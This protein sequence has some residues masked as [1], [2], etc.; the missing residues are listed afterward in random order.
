MSA[1]YYLSRGPTPEGP[2]EEARLVQM[3][4][5]G[6]LT[7]GGVCPVGQNQ[8][9][10]IDS[11]PVFAQALAARRGLAQPAPVAPTIPENYPAAPRAAAAEY[12]QPAA[13]AQPNVSA[14]GAQPT[15][16]KSN[17]GLVL[18][19]A[20]GV[21]VLLIGGIAI[22]VYFIFFSSGGAR[23]ISQAVPRD[24]ELLIDVPSVRKGLLDLHDVKFLDTSLRDDKQ[25]LDQAADSLAKAFDLSASDAV[26]L[27]AD[28]ETAGISAR[29]LESKPEV[30][31]ALG[32]RSA[33]PAEVLLKSAR[34][35][36]AGTVGQKGRRYTLA[37]KQLAPGAGQD[38]VAK[39][40][41][42]AEIGATDQEQL[43]WFPAQKVLALGDAALVSDVAQ[44]L[45]SGAAN[46]EQNPA[47]QAA[48][49]EFDPG[50]R[51]TAFVDPGALSNVSDPKTKQ[52]I[53]EYFTPA[54]PLT[55]S[56]R[57]NSAGF[58]SSVTA[59]I[60]GSKLPHDDSYEAPQALN[61]SDKLAAETF[62]YLA[63]ST[64]SKLTGADME[65]ML[66]DRLSTL[67]AHT[68]N[69]AEQ[70]LREFEQ[71]L[72]VSTAKLIDGIGG[73][74][75]LGL[76]AS[77]DTTLDQLNNE[78]AAASRVNVTYVQELKDQS[79]FQ[80]LATALKT[81]ILPSA[82]EVLLTPDGAGFTLSPRATP[83]PI[84]LRVKFIDKYLFITAGAN[85]LCDRAE[86]AFTKGTST[87]KD[88]SAHQTALAALPDASHFRLWLDTG[89]LL[90]TLS[91]NALVK[92]RLA[93]SGLALDKL[94]LSG[95]NRIV[96]ALSL[97]SE[98]K[99]DIWTL[100]VDALNL[101]A[102]APLGAG[103][104]AL[105]GGLPLLRAL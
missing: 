49:K 25:V 52:L 28:S 5:S 62:A 20:A 87:L 23:K 89:R 27:L 92:A 86:A 73:Q 26:A 83:L 71:L 74:A 10:S 105:A 6:E 80:K 65:K 50:A 100:R 64:R 24:C 16:K 37:R 32:L 90:Q 63:F 81:R 41:S 88:D 95:P 13:P 57:I 34:F 2:L 29:K 18:G 56:F 42:E 35:A 77:P 76:A 33:A 53:D 69:R 4:D 68:Y 40:L 11:I 104:A 14:P 60:S 96:T 103:G 54:G 1:M 79:E 85:T 3:I 72:G 17:L 101:Q 67:D 31:I 30:V 15:A 44:V 58:V 12:A 22:A 36:S 7:Q 97:K 48:Q 9:I 75:V 66:L 55:S 91:T 93:E 38:L 46:I 99:L 94:T 78:Q 45:E 8:W 84:S 51:L 98:V 21:G 59:H 43:V 61:L 19:L 47:Y 39:S 70:G 82:R 102:F